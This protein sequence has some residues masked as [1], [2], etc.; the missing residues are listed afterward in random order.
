MPTLNKGVLERWREEQDVMLIMFAC[1]INE[2]LISKSFDKDVSNVRR[3]LEK[4]IEYMRR[5]K[6]GSWVHPSERIP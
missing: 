3:M 6:T 4:T 2:S 1:G 5:H